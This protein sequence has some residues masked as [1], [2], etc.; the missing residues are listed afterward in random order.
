MGFNARLARDW[1]LTDKEIAALRPLRTPEDVQ[2][3]VS[4][5]PCNFE[6]AGDTCHSVRTVLARN[7]AHCIEGAFLAAAAFALHGRPALLMDFQAEG[8]DDHVIA[9]FRKGSHW[10]AVSKSNRIWLRWRDPIYRSLRELAMS[11]FH[12]YVI[13]DRK[14]LRTYSKPFD[15]G[16]YDH[17]YWVTSQEGCWAMAEEIDASQHYP[18]ISKQQARQLRRRE[19]FEQSIDDIWEYR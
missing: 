8:D 14:T 18:L 11:Y 15:I 13:A 19:R 16:L 10:G 9:L 7:E 6:Q 12:E 2:S 4:A 17:A 5:I 1:G 3:F